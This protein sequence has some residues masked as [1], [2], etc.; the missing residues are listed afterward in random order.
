M[1]YLMNRESGNQKARMKTTKWSMTTITHPYLN[2]DREEHED[3]HDQV[4]SVESSTAVAGETSSL[5]ISLTQ[6][7]LKR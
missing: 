5:T 1:L 3:L 6:I 7:P 4:E 2:G